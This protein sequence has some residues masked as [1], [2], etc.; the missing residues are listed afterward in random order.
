MH[1]LGFQHEHQRP[2]RDDYIEVFEDNIHPSES[3]RFPNAF[4]KFTYNDMSK[5]NKRKSDLR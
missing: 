2:D 5:L 3:N 1:A 4:T